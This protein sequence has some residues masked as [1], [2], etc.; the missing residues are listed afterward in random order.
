MI[1]RTQNQRSRLL[2][3]LRQGV[4]ALSVLYLTITGVLGLET[5][6]KNSKAAA[7]EHQVSVAQQQVRNTQREIDRAKS[8]ALVSAPSDLSAVARLQSAVDRLAS[9]Q[10]CTVSEFRAS[11]EVLPY[12]T[13]FAKTTNVS[14][15]GQVE[16]SVS[17]AGPVKNV[18]ATLTGL[19][20]ENV[21]IEFDTLEITRDK[22]DSAGDATVIAHVTLRV[23]I[24]TSKDGS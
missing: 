16:T 17:L 19:L 24:R 15:W 11:S 7:S 6:V 12:L 20:D 1:A 21:P 22:V 18:I 8:M 4:V 2:T 14:G 5:V 3:S 10:N 13:R 23:L 9:E